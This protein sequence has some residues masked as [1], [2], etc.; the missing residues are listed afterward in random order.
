MRFLSVQW[1]SLLN[2]CPANM[3]AP[4]LKIRHA[5]I[6]KGATARALS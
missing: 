2:R 6:T 4:V 5:Q 1:K 3:Y